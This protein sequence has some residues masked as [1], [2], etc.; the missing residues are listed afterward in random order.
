M[1]WTSAE[2]C[3][4]PEGGVRWENMEGY[5]VILDFC[6]AAVNKILPI[7]TRFRN[8]TVSRFESPDKESNID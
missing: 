5:M 1:L 8:L 7:C 2:E 4:R 6:S 3:R